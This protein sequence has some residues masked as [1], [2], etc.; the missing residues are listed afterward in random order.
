[1]ADAAPL[2]G[3]RDDARGR[4]S[5][6]VAYLVNHYP[7]V[8]HSFIRREIV[9]LEQLGMRVERIALR[10]WDTQLAD[11]QDEAERGRTR[12][13][14]QGG[15]AGLAMGALG[16][17]VSRPSA[18]LAAAKL[19][20]H[21]ARGSDRSVPYHLAYLAEACVVAR[22]LREAGVRHVHAHF[23]T[24][25]AEVA[26]LAAPLADATWSFTVH[27]PDEF[28]RPRAIGL[29]EKIRRAAF[30]V[31]ISSYTRSQLFRWVGVELWSKVHV[32][33]CGLDAAFH[34]GAPGAP[35]S[36]RQLVC[37]GRLSEQKGHLL[38][39]DAMR[40]VFDRGSTFHLV[41]AGDG[42]LRAEVERRVRALGLEAH[43]RITGWISSE[44][45][46]RE[47]LAARALVLPS[48]AEGLPVVIMEALALRRPVVTTY[49]AGIPEL[50]GA[51]CGWLAPAGD[52]GALAD[53][54][55][56][57]LTADGETLAAMGDEG[58]SRALSLHDVTTEAAKLS[59]LFR[60]LAARR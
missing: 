24:N 18:F 26:M 45:V 13:V 20:L 42:E 2:R 36:A 30:V 29:A 39:L 54:I 38:L 52:A 44:E 14:L 51:D 19:A 34:A 56:A 5:E 11:P 40:T 27:G 21:M 4:G 23:G 35:S 12:F 9:A 53:A 33:R 25:S 22:W 59:T 43:V 10:G 57:C 47:L 49:V 7:A 37:V 50:V 41:L 55:E 58:R 28:D 17:L 1:M 60:S 48:F 8:S 15:A 3:Q 16:A 6:A 32:V 46:R 31:G